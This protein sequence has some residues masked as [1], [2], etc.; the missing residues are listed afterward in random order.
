VVWLRT[1]LGP[2]WCMS[3]QHWWC[4]CVHY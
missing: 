4:G 1:L 2:N 3:V